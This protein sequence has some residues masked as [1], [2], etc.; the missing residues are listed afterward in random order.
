MKNIQKIVFVLCLAVTVQLAAQE[1]TKEVVTT[2]DDTI[3]DFQLPTF[4]Q[5][6][7]DIASDY[8]KVLESLPDLSTI[9]PFIDKEIRRGFPFEHNTVYT[10]RNFANEHSL[11]PN[12]SPIRFE[13]RNILNNI[14]FTGFDA[15]Q[16]CHERNR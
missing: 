13:L 5:L 15:N 8:T 9:G 10:I 1:P 12:I 11:V 16:F 2:F 14:M 7:N 6:S 3:E 4:S